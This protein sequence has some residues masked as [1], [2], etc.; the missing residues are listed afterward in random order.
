MFRLKVAF[1]YAFSKIRRQRLTSVFIC[2]GIAAGIFAMFLIMSIMNGLQSKQIETLRSVESFDIIVWNTSLKPEDIEQID[3]IDRVFEF[4]ETPVL[5]NN[6]NSSSS[7]SARIRAYDPSFFDYRRVRG[8]F[9]SYPIAETGISLSYNIASSLKFLGGS[10]FEITFLR[11]GKTATIVPYT[12]SIDVTA[13]YGSALTEFN[14]STVLTSLDTYK[15]ILGERNIG[16]GIFCSSSVE[17]IA[18]AIQDKDSNAEVITWKQYNNAVYGALVLEK[19]IMYVFLSFMFLIICVN[20]RNSTRR[21]IDSRQIEGAM[22]RALGCRRGDIRTIFVLQGLV[23]CI[24]GEAIGTLFGLLALNNMDSIL[25]FIG[26]VSGSYLFMSS[27]IEP[28][29][30]TVEITVILCA[31]LLLG[32]IYTYAGCRKVFRSEIMEVIYDVSD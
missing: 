22:L 18:K 17:K 4:A 25:D 15:S 2:L 9:T 7:V 30:S 23:I 6:L 21:L 10:N 5:I 27:M 19:A 24:I 16:L 28:S 3:G 20:L 13:Y 8:N 12:Q 14:D 31:V 11:P 26:K 1:R 32:F 29:L